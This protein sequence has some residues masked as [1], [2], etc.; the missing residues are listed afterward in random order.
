MP[1]VAIALTRRKKV[2]IPPLAY[3]LFATTT[4]L[5][6]VRKN[7]AGR[8][9]IGLGS[10]L[11]QRDIRFRADAPDRGQGATIADEAVYL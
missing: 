8:N 4:T 6:C 2:Q 5:L 10:R 11:D 3:G 1:G 7:E 9:Q